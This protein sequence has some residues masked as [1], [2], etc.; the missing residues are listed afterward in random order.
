M[1]FYVAGTMKVINSSQTVKARNKGKD[2]MI[3]ILQSGLAYIAD[4]LGV[5]HMSWLRSSFP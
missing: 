1:V 2:I 3:I 4:N 5:S